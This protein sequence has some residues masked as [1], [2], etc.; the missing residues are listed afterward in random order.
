MKKDCPVLILLHGGGFTYDSAVMQNIPFLTEH[1]A[2]RG[3]IL[4]IPPYRL[5]VFGMLDLGD[6]KVVPKN[7]GLHDVIFGLKWVQ[8]E[9][10]NFGGNPDNVTLYGNS[11]G[12]AIVGMLSVAPGVEKMWDK[13]ISSG[14]QTAMLPGKNQN[15]TMNILKKANVSLNKI[16]L[17]MKGFWRF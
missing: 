17:K 6:E 7:L 14:A 16:A 5:G 12:A 4:V 15:I 2:S 3:I 10:S 8:N 9:I 1:Y 11:G 13:I